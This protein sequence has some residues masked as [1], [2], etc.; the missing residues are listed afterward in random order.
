MRWWRRLGAVLAL[1]FAAHA[2]AGDYADRRVIGFSPDG[3]YFAFE[4]YSIQ[5]GSGFP[6]ANIY[7]IDTAADD[8]VSGTPVRV[9]IDNDGA[10]LGEARAQAMDGARALLRSLQAGFEGVHV[11]VNPVTEISADP[12]R[13][14]F[15][16]SRLFPYA[17]QNYTLTLTEYRLPGR[18]CPDFGAPYQGFRLVLSGP[19]GTRTLSQDTRIP[20][21]RS[22]PLNYGISDVFTYFP[23]GGG[24]PVLIILTNVFSLGFE[25]PDRRFIAT[26]ARL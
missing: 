11:V 26:A 19:D 24:R 4:E 12:H 3:A 15:I 8:W 1:T 10:R 23:A 5:D 14:T 16:P 22:C 18:D 17:E 6:Y 13:V 20:K 21:S 9:R 2:Q 7:V 25:G